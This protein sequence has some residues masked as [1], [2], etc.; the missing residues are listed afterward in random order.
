M[1]LH[2]GR[3]RKRR[4]TNSARE[5]IA[6]A[7]E[8]SFEDV[9]RRTAHEARD[10][11]VGRTLIQPL[12][13]VELLQQPPAHDRDAVAH[14]HRLD[15]VVRDVHRRDRELSLDAQDLGAH[16]HAKLRVEVRERL[17]HEEDLGLAHD[18]APHR[19]TLALAAGQLA[20]L[21]VEMVDEADDA[22]RLL[23]PSPGFR[24]RHLPHPQREP[25]V[26]RNRHVW[27]E[28]VVLEDHRNVA[29]ARRQVVHDAL[30]DPDLAVRDLLETRDHAQ[31]GRLS[32]AGRAD[33][34]DEL[35][36]VDIEVEVGDGTVAVTVGLGHVVEGDCG[37][38]ELLTP[39]PRPRMCS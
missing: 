4:R 13:H 12:R 9:H 8:R 22:R 11:E 36:V 19:H 31:R 3:Q 14:R 16:L 17:V 23:D 10:E 21:P 2:P 37:H 27:V 39:L 1:P 30:A 29:R 25:D 35:A 38:G 34:H 7:L 5:G 20:R 28:R 6:F 32:A 15:L 24:L 33:E 26:L 18:R